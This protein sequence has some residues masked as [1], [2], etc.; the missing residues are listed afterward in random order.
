MSRPEKNEYAEYYET[1]VSLVEETD[2][3][4]ALQHQLS[5]ME[6][7]FAEITEEKGAYA[8]AEGKWSIKQLVGH[9][10][11]GERIFSYRALRISRSDL[12]PIEGFEQD[13]YIENANFNAAKLSDLLDEFA[14]VRR[15]NILLFKNL[16]AG[17]WS[18]TGTASDA[19]VS[20]RALA[21]IMVGHF[22]HHANVLKTRYLA[23]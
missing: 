2:I 18:R 1:Y 11:D 15:A 17:A 16:T 3:V 5:E 20:V 6:N 14:L 13:G 9:M 4:S 12:T 7:L 8:Y 21:Y 19:E 10:I 22:R 23:R